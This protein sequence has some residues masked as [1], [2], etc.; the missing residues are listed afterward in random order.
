MPM[1][2]MSWLSANLTWLRFPSFP[3]AR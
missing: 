3:S 2:L 1:V